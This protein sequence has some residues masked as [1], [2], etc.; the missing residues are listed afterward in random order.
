MRPVIFLVDMNAFFISCEMTR[1]PELRGKP[2]AV[3]GDPSRRTGI[4][5]AAS[6]E[7]RAYGVRTTMLIH[8]AL[9]L[10]PT[11]VL[12]PPDHSFYEQKSQEVMAL[13]ARYAPVLEQ[14]SIDEAWLDMTGCEALFGQPVEAARMIM[15]AINEELGLWCSI[16]IAENKFCAKMAS[17]MHKPHGI[18]ELWPLDVP[19]KL[20]TLP[21]GAMYGVGQKT[22]ARLASLGLR[23][24]GDLA[25]VKEEVLVGFLGKSG[26]EIS[27][28]ARGIDP[29]P[30]IARVEDSVK[31]IG[32]ST[33][34]PQDI[35]VL[36][37]ARQVLLTLS[38]D[39]GRSA[40]KHDLRG[41]TVQITLKY[42]D[43]TVITRQ[44]TVPA[45]YATQDI[46]EAG[47]RLLEQ[48]WQPS[49]P[50]RLI[51]ISLSGFS[52]DAADKQVSF[53]EQLAKPEQPPASD[54]KVLVDQAMDK[55]RDR[56]GDRSITRAKQ[57]KPPKQK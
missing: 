23:T 55:I 18:T 35:A 39:V 37:Q 46:Y 9:R 49:R 15:K 13:L 48:N 27:R 31:S 51:G 29:D 25:K 53:F 40:R 30:V 44:A 20:W 45:T 28:H 33:T 17:E 24:I 2:A 5:L 42:S 52:D 10:C 36:E 4:I 50:V 16:G 56:F 11:L 47:C 57:I 21:A 14:N 38:D 19:E 8:D 41:R 54:R 43:F 26:V 22:S 12:V 32:R 7:A 6:Y 34:L 3:A 1:Q